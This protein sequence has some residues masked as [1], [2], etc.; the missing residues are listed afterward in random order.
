MDQNAKLMLDLNQ[1][2]KELI[3][4]ENLPLLSELINKYNLLFQ[5]VDANNLTTLHFAV[6]MN[7][8]KVILFLCQLMTMQANNM[9]NEEENRGINIPDI[10]GRTPLHQAAAK[11][12]LEIIECLIRFGADVNA[13]T[14]SGETPLM[15]AIAFY[16]TNAAIFL[17]KYGAD[18]EMINEVNGKNCLYQTYESKNTELIPIMEKFSEKYSSIIKT[19]SKIGNKNYPRQNYLQKLPDFLL[20][21]AINYLIP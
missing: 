15:K 7:R 16:Q 18:P 17:L 12:D 9:S 8:K 5:P 1:K 20:K 13:K 3:V 4:M 19:I 2:V 6:Q 10:L 21:R 11:G 14:I